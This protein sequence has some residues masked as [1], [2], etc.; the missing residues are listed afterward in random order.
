MAHGIQPFARRRW[1]GAGL[2]LALA[3]GL[4]ACG[5]PSYPPARVCSDCTATSAS[6]AARTKVLAAEAT[7]KSAR[8]WS[9]ELEEP[10]NQR[11]LMQSQLASSSFRFPLPAERE[12]RS[13][14]RTEGAVRRDLPAAR[15][16][17]SA[18]GSGWIGRPVTLVY[19]QSAE[20]LTL[21][22]KNQLR[23]LA[24]Q[25]RRNDDLWVELQAYAS[26][27]NGNATQAR[28]V[29]LTR[30]MAVRAYLIEQDV[31]LHQ[32]DVRALG[33]RAAGGPADRVDIVPAA[34]G[35]S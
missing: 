23:I 9:S 28:H 20:H 5:G 29:A 21:E 17:S 33:N 30:A 16:A 25:L 6:A 4:T 14:A 27:Q 31:D 3:L 1:A 8:T 19:A 13:R 10:R 18:S 2:L 22:M 24:L 35:R 26:P 15:A 12:T 32:L 7:R 11:A 34:A